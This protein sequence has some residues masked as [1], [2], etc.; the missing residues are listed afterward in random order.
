[1]ELIL[2]TTNSHKVRELRELCR[3]LKNIEILS[4]R[5]FPSYVQI[6]ET[7]MT[8]LEN[9]ILKAEDAAKN[10]NKLVLAE[11]SGLF[12]PAL[13]GA[14]GVHSRRYASDNAT[15]LE[16][17]RKLLQEL[18]NVEQF[19]R[20]AYFE[21]CIAIASP[22][23]I[24]KTSTGRCEGYIATEER[25][26]NGFGYDSIFIKNDYNKTFAE[27]EDLVKNQISHRMK[28]FQKI[29]STLE[30]LGTVK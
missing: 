5:D 14:P 1:M 9:A 25:G 11:D 6:E 16:N 18:K 21:C 2:A 27:L 22:E 30:V 3:N 12:I 8:L 15:D 26:R 17:R 10:L 13:N 19:Q 4:L 29:L 20:A 28:A 23:K 7:G 24:I